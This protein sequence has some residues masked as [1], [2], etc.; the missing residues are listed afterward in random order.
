MY[1]GPYNQNAREKGGEK[2]IFLGIWTIDAEGG[3][4]KLIANLKRDGYRLCWTPDGKYI[5]YEERIKGMDFELCKVSAE[6]GEPEKMNIRGRSAAC[7]PDGKK[8]AYS[9]R[10]EGYYEFWLVENFLP[11]IKAEQ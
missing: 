1:T 8:I 5:I 9:R 2:E 11:E 6:G 7:S 3:E 10:L 4:P